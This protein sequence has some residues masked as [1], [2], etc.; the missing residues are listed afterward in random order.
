MAYII[1]FIPNK[2]S[3]KLTKSLSYVPL[4]QILI[5]SYPSPAQK[6]L[7]MHHYCSP[8]YNYIIV[9]NCVYHIQNSRVE[10]AQNSKIGL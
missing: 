3:S 8:F 1:C 4:I 5:A 7:P 2:R 10:Y 9:T 6:P